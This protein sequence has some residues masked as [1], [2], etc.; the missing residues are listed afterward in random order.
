VLG[1]I[2]LLLPVILRGMS[3]LEFLF[4]PVTGTMAGAGVVAGWAEGI[5]LALWTTRRITSAKV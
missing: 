5:A 2:Y 3:G 1:T 4:M